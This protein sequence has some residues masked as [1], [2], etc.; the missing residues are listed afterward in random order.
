LINFFTVRKGWPVFICCFLLSS[1]LRGQD[2]LATGKHHHP[3]RR[4][5]AAPV[6]LFT[7]AALAN[8]FKYDIRADRNAW[9]PHFHTSVDNY[10]QYAPIAVVYGLNLAGVG[11]KN[12]LTNRTLLLIKSELVMTALVQPLKYGTQVLRPD[13]SNRHSFPSGHTAEAF[14]AATFLH[15]EFGHRSVWYSIGAYSAATAVGAMRVM[16]NKHW[17]TD[18]L[19]G[20]GIGILSTELVY[21]THK[22]RWAKR[23]YTSTVSITPVYQNGPGVFMLMQ[24]GISIRTRIADREEITFAHFIQL[25]VSTKGVC[26]TDVAH[27]CIDFL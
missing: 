2:T 10:L 21:K 8:P 5:L 20:A 3:W 16:N 27:D 22:F 19:T 15:K 24:P 18:V 23:K 1:L 25:A 17:I 7:A 9:N 4:I 6:A 26:F 13:G 11:G 12:D 14:T